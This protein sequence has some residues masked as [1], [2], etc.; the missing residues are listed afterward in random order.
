MIVLDVLSPKRVIITHMK[1]DDYD[2]YE[3]N[4]EAFDGENV[5]EKYKSIDP[6]C[7]GTSS[8]SAIYF[9]TFSS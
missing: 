3:K 5:I 2:E 9:A 6:H 4:P 7:E 1:D 8:Q